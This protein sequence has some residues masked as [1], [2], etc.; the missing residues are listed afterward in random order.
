MLSVVLLCVVLAAVTAASS[1]VI[2]LCLR[3]SPLHLQG[4]GLLASG[5]MDAADIP[6]PQEPIASVAT[7]LSEDELHMQRLREFFAENRPENVARVPELF[8]KV[9]RQAWAALELKYPGKTAKF[10]VVCAAAYTCVLPG[11]F[12]FLDCQC[13]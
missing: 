10:T 11:I 9:G 1:D 2:A 8:A 7:P 12:L 3:E 4:L 13:V 5:S 6:A